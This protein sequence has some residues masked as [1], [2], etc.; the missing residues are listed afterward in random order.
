MRTGAWAGRDPSCCVAACCAALQRVLLRCNM[1][2]FVATCHAAGAWADREL[3]S[4]YLRSIYMTGLMMI[5]DQIQPVT[6][7]EYIFIL[8]VMVLGSRDHAGSPLATSTCGPGSPLAT[9]PPGLGS[10][11]QVLGVVLSAV[12]ISNM[13]GYFAAL[14]SLQVLQP[15]SGGGTRMVVWE[16]LR[17]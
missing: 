12:V 8:C 11:H 7:A 1:S 3:P 16:L 17:C 14:S 15:H 4:I 5:G 2:C 6:D 10:T 9:S 13:S